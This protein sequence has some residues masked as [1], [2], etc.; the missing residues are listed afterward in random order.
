MPVLDVDCEE[1]ESENN[2]HGGRYH[3]IKNTFLSPYCTEKW[4][5]IFRERKLRGLVPSFHI[6]VS[7]SDLYFPKVGLQTQYS[8]I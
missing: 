3:C 8:N 5:K 4:K 6:H 7:V 2:T 1:A